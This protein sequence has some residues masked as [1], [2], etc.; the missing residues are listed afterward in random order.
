MSKFLT[1]EACNLKRETLHEILP[2]VNGPFCI[3]FMVTLAC[4]FKCYYCDYQ[5]RE[6]KA[7]IM[8]FENFKK[9]I[10]HLNGFEKFKVFNF[11]G[12]G[13]P[14]THRDIARMVEYV[15]NKD[16]SKTIEITTNGSLLTHQMSDALLS[17]GV[18][19]I[20]IS[21]QGRSSQAYQE[22]CGVAVDYDRFKEQ[23]CYFRDAKGPNVVLFVKI[24]DQMIPTPEARQDFIREYQGIADEYEIDCL[25][26]TSS[27]KETVDAAY[28]NTL[29]GQEFVPYSIC[30]QPFYSATIYPNG[31]AY[32]CC[33]LPNPA[34]LCNMVTE[35]L[36]DYWHGP[37][38]K[39]FLCQH[40]RGERNQI[41]VC[42][43]CTL[44][45]YISAPNDN[46]DPYA[47]ELLKKY[48]NL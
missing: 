12:G 1:P 23:L 34:P 37:K 3:R 25:F 14:L 46:L 41:P 47:A 28:D 16:L 38:H 30:P 32:P 40:L 45:Q 44:F 29:Y 24:I 9:C 13:E 17:A 19:R 8:S 7:E 6:F 42:S 36:A 11:T 33:P 31:Y 4:N 27:A 21:L 39:A 18:D 26:P 43:E 48:E 35:R 10:D 2:L 22:T 5:N 20:K 15:K